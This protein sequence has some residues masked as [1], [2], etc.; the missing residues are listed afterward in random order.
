MREKITSE[1][2]GPDDRPLPLPP[3]TGHTRI[4]SRPSGSRC[5]DTGQ[6]SRLEQS[7]RHWAEGTPRSDVRWSRRRMLLIFLL[8]RYTGAK[9]NEVLALNPFQDFNLEGQS[10][11][12]GKADATPGRPP[13]EVQI[14][15][16]LAKE[17]QAALEDP[18]FKKSLGTL[19]KVDPGHVRRKFYERAAACGL[20]TGLG[21]PDVIRKSRAVELM[22]NNLPLPV[23]QK[24]LGHSSP[25]LTASFVSFADA[26]IQQVARFFLEK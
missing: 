20:A 3:R 22:Q 4:I 17:I 16:T 23:V 12:F 9:L 24:I 15:A 11:V 13:R 2:Q 1:S 26:D 25:N 6:L 19:F 10:V 5:L 7:F 14:P 18:A 21:G 8:I